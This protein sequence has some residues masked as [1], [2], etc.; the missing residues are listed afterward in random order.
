MTAQ[1]A[2]EEAAF[3]PEVRRQSRS[4]IPSPQ[5]LITLIPSLFSFILNTRPQNNY[6]SQGLEDRQPHVS[7]LISAQE[8]FVQ[9]LVDQMTH[10]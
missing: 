7:K 9:C 2:G 8:H 4:W 10:R 6:I 1:T 3:L 5:V